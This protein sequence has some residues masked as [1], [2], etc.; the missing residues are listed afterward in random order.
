MMGVKERILHGTGDVS[1]VKVYRWFVER[2]G[3][4]HRNWRNPVVSNGELQGQSLMN[5]VAVVG[6]ADSTHRNL[7]ASANGSPPEF[8]LDS[9]KRKDGTCSL[10][11][12]RPRKLTQA[13]DAL[14]KYGA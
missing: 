7:H 13:M 5:S 14:A 12:P 9:S 6:I 3:E 1:H 11:P 2:A 4:Y 8:G 10:A